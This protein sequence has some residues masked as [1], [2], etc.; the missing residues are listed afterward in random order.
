M[1]PSYKAIALFLAANVQAA[2][3]IVLGFEAHEFF[4]ERFPSF[5][6]SGVLV[7]FL[8]FALVVRNYYLLIKWSLKDKRRDL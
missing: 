4:L 2:L 6:Y 1:D 7:A 8:V 5:K 3:F